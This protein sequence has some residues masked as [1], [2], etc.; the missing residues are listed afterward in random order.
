MSVKEVIRVGCGSAYADD[1]LRPAFELAEKGNLDYICFDCLAERTLALAQLRRLN[2]PSKGYDLRLDELVG[3]FL[4]FVNKGLKIIGNMG[5]AN[6]HGALERAKE[7]AKKLD[8]SN[9]RIIAIEGDDVLDVIREL[10]PVVE[11]TGSKLS[12]LEG[13]LVSANAYIG[14]QPIVEALYVGAN[15]IIG[16][17]IADPSLFLAPL[18]F[19]FNWDREDWDKLAQGTAVGH[20]LECGTHVTGGNFADPPYRIVPGLDDLGMPY[21]DVYANGNAVISKLPEAGGLVTTH[22]C[23]AQLVYEVHDP[24][25]YITPDVTCDFSNITVEQVSRDQVHVNG[26]KGTKAPTRLKVL[27]GVQEGYIGEGEFSFAGPGAYERAQLALEVLKRRFERFYKGK[28]KDIRF[29]LIGVNSIHGPASPKPINPPYEVRVRIAIRTDDRKT[30]EAW[31]REAEWQY[32]GPSGCG[33][34]RMAVRQ[35]IAMYSTYIDRDMVKIRLV[36]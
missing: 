2:D 33:G 31:A 32:F 13:K 23:K 1:D 11:E 22:T 20:L 21:A 25:A 35:V 18:M 29:D 24:K 14:A 5:A 12:Q 26:A 3:S 28:E 15:F 6:P 8:I 34:I 7:I 27:L 4:P 36:K 30:A 9:A 16:G 17:R 19:E 10:D